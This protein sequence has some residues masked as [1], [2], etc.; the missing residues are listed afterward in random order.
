MRTEPETGEHGEHGEHGDAGRTT[1]E[2][3][4]WMPMA[5]RAEEGRGHAA[6]RPGE[7]LAAGDPGIPEWGNLP[8]GKP[9]RRRVS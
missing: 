7:A 6:K 3:A 1:E 8:G 2:G 4:R 5:S 9:G